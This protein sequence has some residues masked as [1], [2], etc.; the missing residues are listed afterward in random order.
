MRISKHRTLF[1][2]SVAY[3][4]GLCTVLLVPKANFL[5][6]IPTMVWCGFMAAAFTMMTRAMTADFGDE[7]RLEQGR[8]R[9]TLIYAFTGLMAKVASAMAGV[10]TY[11]VLSVIGFNPAEGAINTPE[12]LQGLKLAFTVGPIVFVML[13]GASFLGWKLDAETHARIRTDLEARDSL[14]AEAPVVESLTGDHS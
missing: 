10:I 3:S 14:H 2:A 9:I 5:L 12:A 7:I 6:A 8:E 1:L 4:L 11:A 13:G